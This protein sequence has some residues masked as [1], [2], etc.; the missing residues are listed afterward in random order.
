MTDVEFPTYETKKLPPGWEW[1]TL[2]STCQIIQG[3]SPPSYTYNT[4]RIGLP[5][6]Q[7]K[8]EFGEMYPIVIKWCSDPGK[9]AEAEDVLISIRAPVG[10]TNLAQERSCIGRGLVALHPE[11]QMPSR[12]FLYFL[13]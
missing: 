12:Y 1:A 11:L 3:Q 8:A 7:G 13:S 2:D 6:F 4:Q 9:V 5:F 10:P